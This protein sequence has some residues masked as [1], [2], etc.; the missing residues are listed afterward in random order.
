MDCK[1]VHVVSESVR[2]LS[3]SVRT[4]T[5]T[6]VCTLYQSV[7]LLPIHLHALLIAQLNTLF[8]CFSSC[9]PRGPPYLEAII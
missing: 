2:M 3:E 8:F 9:D 5:N 6:F 7:L 1:S 4:L